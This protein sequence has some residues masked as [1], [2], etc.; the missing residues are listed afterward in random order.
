MDVM[1]QAVG[2]C[3]TFVA[4]RVAAGERPFVDRLEHLGGW[5][6]WDHIQSWLTTTTTGFTEALLLDR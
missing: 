2:V 5:P 4:A 1:V 6:H 3:R